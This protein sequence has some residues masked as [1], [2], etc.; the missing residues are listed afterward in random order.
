MKP[1]TIIRLAIKLK[2]IPVKESKDGGYSLNLLDAPYIG[3]NV[4]FI[5]F[6]SVYAYNRY[7]AVQ[8]FDMQ[9]LIYISIG[10]SVIALVPVFQFVLGICLERSERVVLYCPETSPLATI[11]IILNT[12]AYFAVVMAQDCIYMGITIF[13]DYLTGAAIVISTLLCFLMVATMLLTAYTL[14]ISLSNQLD[15]LLRRG[16]IDLVDLET[17]LELYTN[18]GSA[19]EY[20]GLLTFVSIQLTAIGTIYL[21]IS[22]ANFWAGTISSAS[23][24]LVVICFVLKAEDIYAKVAQVSVKGRKSANRQSSLRE[25]ANMRDKEGAFITH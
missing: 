23:S 4:L 16:C 25:L 11:L 3:W 10:T 12:L 20:V 19:L 17:A 14:C 8:I 7:M 24:I 13:Q 1:A 5:A 15:K 21:F 9:E 22:G 18:V 2:I 6:F